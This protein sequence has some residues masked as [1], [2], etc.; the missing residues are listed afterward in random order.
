MNSI[1]KFEKWNNHREIIKNQQKIIDELKA[2]NEQLKK[3]N[4]LLQESLD[5][6]LIKTLKAMDKP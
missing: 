1:E 2:E 6:D 5:D 4:K 3:V